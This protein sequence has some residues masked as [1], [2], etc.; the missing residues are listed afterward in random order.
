[1][2]Y[3]LCR[4]W[5]SAAHL[6]P[7]VWSHLAAADSAPR[8][9]ASAWHRVH[10]AGQWRLAA[11]A[12][13]KACHGLLSNRWNTLLQ[14]CHHAPTVRVL[15]QVWCLQAGQSSAGQAT[16]ALTLV[17]HAELGCFSQWTMAGSLCSAGLTAVAAVGLSNN[18]VQAFWLDLEG[19]HT[20]SCTWQC[21]E[22]SLLYSMA[23]LP[24]QVIGVVHCHAA[25]QDMC[26]HHTGINFL[27]GQVCRAQQLQEP[28]WL[29][30]A[31]FSWTCSSGLLTWP[32]GAALLPP[33]DVMQPP[34]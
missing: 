4:C 33:P 27:C 5:V 24:R 19:T 17:E 6:W 12:W 29:R 25:A 14:I 1:M 10:A 8:W 21:T 16:T 15:L 3:D 26:R 7:R 32:E 11:A 9:H 13:W 28:C 23:L 22:R 18:S 31:P 34:C 20:S 2:R 30:L